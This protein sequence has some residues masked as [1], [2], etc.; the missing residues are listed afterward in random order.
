VL[1][2]DAFHAEILALDEDL[3][4]ELLAH[5]R[6]VRRTSGLARPGQRKGEE[7]WQGHSMT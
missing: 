5:A 1:F 3:Q 7:A 2:H 6:T 4:D